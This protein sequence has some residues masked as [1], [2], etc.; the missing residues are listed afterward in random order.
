MVVRD[1][2]ANFGGDPGN[3]TIFGQSGGADKVTALMAMPDA[4]GLFHKAIVQSGAS[5]ALRQRTKEDA[6]K[7][8][9]AAL[10]KLGLTR[11]NAGDILKMSMQQIVSHARARNPRREKSGPSASHRLVDGRSLPRHPFDPDAPEI[12][13]DV[14]MIIGRTETEYTFLLTEN[15]PNLHLNE[16]DMRAKLAPVLGDHTDRVIAQVQS[17]TS[18]GHTDRALLVH[19]HR[20]SHGPW[21]PRPSHA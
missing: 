18:G 12:S 14:P 7:D 3:V 16:A 1:N 17:H 10:Q 21:R 20:I 11:D 19:Q 6:A 2:I 15:D 8:T 5:T 4:K 13:A 9:N